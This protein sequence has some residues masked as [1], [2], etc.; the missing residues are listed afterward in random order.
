MSDLF[1]KDVPVEFIRQVFDVIQ[2]PP[3]HTYQMLTKRSTRMK[4]LAGELDWPE[5]HWV[6][7]TVE[8]QKFHHRIDHLR[9]VPAA[10]KFVG[11]TPLLGPLELDLSG[12]DFVVAGPESGR[13]AREMK[14]E[15]LDQLRLDCA[16]AVVP[17]LTEEAF[18]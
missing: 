1:H 15:W 4:A 11:A 16:A 8:T 7:V 14:D 2:A 12:V 13:K 17:L 6:G 3:R 9:Q 18:D 5:N 10:V